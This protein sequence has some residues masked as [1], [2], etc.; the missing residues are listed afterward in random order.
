M[1]EHQLDIKKLPQKY[2][3]DYANERTI[4]KRNNTIKTSQFIVNKSNVLPYF[5]N[6]NVNITFVINVVNTV[7]FCERIHICRVVQ[8]NG[9]YACG[10][11]I[12]V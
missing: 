8:L 10:Y 1:K 7:S 4:Y 3:H 2:A 5:D 9:Y 11:H 12:L 6:E